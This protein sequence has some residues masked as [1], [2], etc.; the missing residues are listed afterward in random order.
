MSVQ[1][2]RYRSGDWSRSQFLGNDRHVRTKGPCS[3]VMLFNKAEKEILKF[4]SQGTR[5]TAKNPCEGG[6]FSV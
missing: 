2:A 6:L 1:L 3:E 5:Y 4:K